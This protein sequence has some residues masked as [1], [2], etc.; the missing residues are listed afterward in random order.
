VEVVLS[1]DYRSIS[2]QGGTLPT[3]DQ[4]GS[5][6]PMHNFTRQ[7]NLSRRTL[8]Q[9]VGSTLLGGRWNSSG[10]ASIGRA[11]VLAK[12]KLHLGQSIPLANCAGDL[13]S[14]TWA[15]DDNL[16]AAS[17]DTSGFKNVCS[18]NLAINRISGS[19]PP[20]LQGFTINCMAAYGRASETR[21]EDGGMWK[22]CGLT[23]V[24]G[25]LY[26]S[27]SRQLTCA[28][29]PRGVWQ[30]RFSPFWIQETW[31]SSI[32]KSTDHGRTWSPAPKLGQAMFPGRSFGTPFFVQYGKDGNGQRDEADAYV[33]ALSNDGTWNNGNWM[34]LGRVARNRIAQ[35]NS[36]DWEFVHGYDDKGKPLWRPRYDDALYVFR[37]P[38]RT[39]MTGVHYLPGLDIYVMPQWHYPYLDDERRRWTVTRLEFYQAPAPWGPW[40]LFHTQEFEP[41]SWYNPCIPSKFIS[42]D[43]RRFWI[44]VAGNFIEGK[45]YYRLNMIP[46]TLEEV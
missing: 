38:N 28:T 24:D 9:G 25:I 40:A 43:G 17:D 19:G 1:I 13:W 30:G 27:V 23:C 16:Y 29:E 44:F 21:K 42:S 14:T 45:R 26:L 39:S 12:L 36:A 37:A 3:T 31:D 2:I 8:L 46:A 11:F 15:D 6:R 22:A 7:S 32:V 18:S 20:D 35:L 33:Y 34:I 41:E 10:S 5:I 4:D